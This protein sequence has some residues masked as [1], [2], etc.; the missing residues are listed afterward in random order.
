MTLF[1]AL[2]QK[3]VLVLGSGASAEVV[4]SIPEDMLLLCC[5]SSPLLL[6][7]RN[8]QHRINV[9]LAE[10]HLYFRYRSA[11]EEFIPRLKVDLLLTTYPEVLKKLQEVQANCLQVL[12]A[13]GLDWF[14]DSLL[15]PSSRK[16]LVRDVPLMNPQLLPSSGVRLMMYALACGASEIYLAGI[17]FWESEY[18]EGHM[19]LRRQIGEYHKSVD[20]YLAEFLARETVSVCV[21]SQKSFATSYFPYRE[22]PAE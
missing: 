20:M 1:R 5:N 9:L 4:K 15:A 12:Q 18:F 21:A 17:D 2:N 16:G 6:L 10:T 19:P 3:R 7:K 8:L 22:L 13:P 11:M 14:C